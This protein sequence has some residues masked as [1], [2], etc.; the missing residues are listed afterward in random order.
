M[1]PKKSLQV[2]I[3]DPD[4]LLINKESLDDIGRSMFVF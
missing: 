4:S 3:K 2:K 1:F